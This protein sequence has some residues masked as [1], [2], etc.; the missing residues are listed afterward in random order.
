MD[1]CHPSLVEAQKVDYGQRLEQ[2]FLDDPV[3]VEQRMSVTGLEF[4][5]GEEQVIAHRDPDL[6][7]DRV[8]ARSQERLDFEV[9]LDPFEEGLDRP[10]GFVDIGDGLGVQSEVV[11]QELKRPALVFIPVADEPQLVGE[12]LS[13]FRHGE[14]DDAVA[15]CVAI[16][17][18]FL[19]SGNQVYEG[20]LMPGDEEGPRVVYPSEPL[21]IH[22][23]AIEAQDAVRNDVPMIPGHGDIGRPPR[24]YIHE[25]RD[26]PICVQAE[27]HLDG[28][29]ALGMF[30]PRE[31]SQAEVHEGR[32]QDED[33]IL[34]LEFMA[35]RELLAAA[36]KSMEEVFVDP[37]VAGPVG[38]GQR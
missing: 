38:V 11:G 36:T 30:G 32:I 16:F 37:V 21:R 3:Q 35:R 31:S 5:V 33:G 22:V 6:R 12:G 15:G 17:R 25:H 7:E 20:G 29:A 8:L 26:I 18:H 19:L 2:R 4:D 27:V 13:G 10:S 28:T 24:S 23:A 1:S 34:E 9:L 14:L